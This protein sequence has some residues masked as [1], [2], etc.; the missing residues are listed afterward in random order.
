MYMSDNELKQEKILLTALEKRNMK[1]FMQLYKCYGEDLLIFAYSQLQ[2]AKLAIQT[3][4]DFFERLWSD[5]KFTAINPPIYKFMV[6]Q[7]QAICE[8]KSIY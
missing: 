4:D 3:V 8:K 5:A 2:D 7:M 1:A 6:E